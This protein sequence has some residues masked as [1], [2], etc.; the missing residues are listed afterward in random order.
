MWT[1][2]HDELDQILNQALS[3][4]PAEPRLGIETRVLRRVQKE[5]PKA[6]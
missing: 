1:D 4:C 2:K 5:V 3:T 6:T